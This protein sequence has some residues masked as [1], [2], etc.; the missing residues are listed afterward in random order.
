MLITGGCNGLGR[1]L[2]EIFGLRSV[3]VAVLDVQEP[4]G[5]KERTEEEE[6]WK[7]YR[8]DVGNVEEVQRVKRQVEK[9][10][11]ILSSSIS[12]REKCEHATITH[13]ALLS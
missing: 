7:W 9:D 10:V 13:V 11:C 3:G 6:G 2:A 1:L 5:G 8:C 12:T 4:E